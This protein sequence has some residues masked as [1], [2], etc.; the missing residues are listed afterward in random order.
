MSKQLALA[1]TCLGLQSE[2]RNDPLGATQRI[3]PGA[4]SETG[5]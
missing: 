3:C 5:R 1:V 2:Y 4:V